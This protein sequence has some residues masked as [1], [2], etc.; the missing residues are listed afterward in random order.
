MCEIF[1]KKI[2]F[3]VLN[4]LGGMESNHG[5]D[6]RLGQSHLWFTNSSTT[7]F[8]LKKKRNRVRSL[9]FCSCLH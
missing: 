7:A 5:M 8:N 2:D 1:K 3:V 4:M 9:Q 6:S